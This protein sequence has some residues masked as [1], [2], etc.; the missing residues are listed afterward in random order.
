MEVEEREEQMEAEEQ[1]M[2]MIDG[3]EE[4]EDDPDLL[5]VLGSEPQTVKKGSLNYD[6]QPA[7]V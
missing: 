6:Y 5:D 7:Q 4:A 3:L 2:I 1:I